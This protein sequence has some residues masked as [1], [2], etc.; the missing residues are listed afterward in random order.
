MKP[1]DRPTERDS[2]QFYDLTQ[3]D[4]DKICELI[5]QIDQAVEWMC[6]SEEGSGEYKRG[7]DLRAALN[8]FLK[9]TAK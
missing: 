6:G 5:L 2:F 8:A 3:K 7:I 4:D 1:E 9:K